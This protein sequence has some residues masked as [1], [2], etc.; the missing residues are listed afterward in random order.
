M[1]DGT[2][3]TGAGS[4]S[5]PTLL[6]LTAIGDSRGIWFGGPTGIYVYSP[7]FGLLRVFAQTGLLEANPGNAC[8]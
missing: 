8:I 3:A 5:R 1:F 2:F 6:L 4:L 7:R